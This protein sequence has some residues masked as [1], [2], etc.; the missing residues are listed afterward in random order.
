MQTVKA[1]LSQRRNRVVWISVVVLLVV[2]LVL[3]YVGRTPRIEDG[4]DTSEQSVPL[5]AVVPSPS[6]S[7]Q[8]PAA[9]WQTENVLDTGAGLPRIPGTV[10]PDTTD[11]KV[12]GAAV[13]DL[14]L[15]RDY[16]AAQQP[17][18]DQ[19]RSSIVAAG[20]KGPV[21]SVS[22]AEVESSVTY[23]AEFVA[24]KAEQWDEN[25]QAGSVLSYETE[26]LGQYQG[27]PKVA[28][29][30]MGEFAHRLTAGDPR[31]ELIQSITWK[32]VTSLSQADGFHGVGHPEEIVVVMRTRDGQRP[33][34][35]AVIRS[36]AHGG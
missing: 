15:N 19:I 27:V 23:T 5:Q 21:G 9:P 4:K 13:V 18:R 30:Q 25:V 31:T 10:L 12:L 34:V 32:G 17:T 20:A 36:E 1:I 29:V 11:F 3:A 16:T 6:A 2:G 7:G 24:G 26:R 33:E 14:M 35:I 22:A 28:R 8:V